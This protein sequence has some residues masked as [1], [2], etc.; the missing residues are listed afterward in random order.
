[1]ALFELLA[2]KYSAALVTYDSDIET[3]VHLNAK[4][5]GP[6]ILR[7]HIKHPLKVKMVTERVEFFRTEIRW[8][9]STSNY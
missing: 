6:H 7:V 4:L 9:N 2:V 3:N 1:M 5:P 8:S